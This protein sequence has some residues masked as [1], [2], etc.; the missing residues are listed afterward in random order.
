[1]KFGPTI[2]EN[3]LNTKIKQ[4]DKFLLKGEFVKCIVLF[5]GRNILHPENGDT[6]FDKIISAVKNG[7]VVNRA[8]M[9]GNSMEMFLAPNVQKQKNK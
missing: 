8:K 2:A 4:I 7:K 9:K 6:I 3:D 1:M 5:S